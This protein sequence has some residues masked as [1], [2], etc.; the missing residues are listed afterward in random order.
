MRKLLVL[1]AVTVVTACLCSCGTELTMP[2]DEYENGSVIY[3]SPADSSG[4]E[5]VTVE[6][7]TTTESKANMN[8]FVSIN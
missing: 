6:E 8:F 4:T 7:I 3:V 5:T 1:T 2:E